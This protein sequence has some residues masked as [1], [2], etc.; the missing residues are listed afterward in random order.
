MSSDLASDSGRVYTNRQLL[1]RHPEDST[2]DIFK[3]E[4]CGK[5]FVLKKVPK[6]VFERS[7]HIAKDLPS[8]PQ[9][10][11][12]VD[13][14]LEDCTLIY[15]YFQGTLLELLEKDSSLLPDE[16]LKIMRAVGEAVQKLHSRNW[17]HTDIKPDNI[18]LDWTSDKNGNK[19]I[20]KV[21]L[22]DFDI[23]CQ[24]DANQVRITPH[25][26]GNVMWRSP[27]A[28][29]GM[30]I[31]PIDIYSLGLVYLYALGA[32]ELI[33]IPRERLQ[34]GIIPEQEVII[35]HFSY[36]GPV[37]ESLYEQI[38]DEKWRK[39]LRLASEV[40]EKEVAARPGLRFEI[41]GDQTGKTYVDLIAG[42]TNLDPKTRSRIDE[43]LAHPY[44]KEC[45]TY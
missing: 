25:A 44:W 29:T 6:G 32:G 26:V 37:P 34:E 39:P 12:H 14:K 45:L 38:H 23:A 33:I 7:Q 19:V 17:I 42:M 24:L 2:F 5:T 4:S 36:F 35:Q 9:L 1:R 40:A 20:T 10:R 13:S 11:M 30:A 27:E 15:D 31:K 22:G 3:A 8:V 41:W 18:F 28:Q 21:A 43:V 16:R